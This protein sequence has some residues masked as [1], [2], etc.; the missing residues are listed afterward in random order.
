[1]LL[2]FCKKFG[3]TGSWVPLP[4]PLSATPG[5]GFGFVTPSNRGP[6]RAAATKQGAMNPAP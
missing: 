5:F 1:M 6:Y 3:Y 2:I 4:S